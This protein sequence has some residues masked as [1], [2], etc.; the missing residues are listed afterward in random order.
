MFTKIELLSFELKQVVCFNTDSEMCTIMH[1][2]Q[3]LCSGSDSMFC[4]H[5]QISCDIQ[6]FIFHF[7]SQ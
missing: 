1:V 7:F 5:L 4:C 3:Q 6:I 2:A